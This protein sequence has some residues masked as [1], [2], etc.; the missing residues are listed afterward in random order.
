[1]F[2]L[3]LLVVTWNLNEPKWSLNA[4]VDDAGI[5]GVVHEAGAGV[6]RDGYPEL[7]VVDD[8]AA[9]HVVHGRRCRGLAD[10]EIVKRAWEKKFLTNFNLSQS[11]KLAAQADTLLLV[12]L[13]LRNK[14]AKSE[15]LIH[16]KGIGEVKDFNST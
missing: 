16:E 13:K 12:S 14:F 10:L 1:M 4:P 2:S 9:V 7:V 6:E 5:A 15:F 11:R 8:R 3:P